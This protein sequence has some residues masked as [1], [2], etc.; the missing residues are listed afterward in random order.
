MLLYGDVALVFF[1]RLLLLLCLKCH[2]MQARKELSCLL[3]LQNIQNVHNE[4]MA[5]SPQKSSIKTN[6]VT[7]HL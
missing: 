5:Y 6:L 2:S 1:I 3:V 4:N 7:H